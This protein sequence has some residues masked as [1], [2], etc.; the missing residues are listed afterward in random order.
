MDQ[1]RKACLF[2]QINIELTRNEHILVI[3]NTQVTVFMSLP[4]SVFCDI[5]STWLWRLTDKINK[6][7]GHLKRET[8]LSVD[9][10]TAFLTRLYIRA[11]FRKF[12]HKIM[13]NVL[14]YLFFPLKVVYLKKKEGRADLHSLP[15]SLLLGMLLIK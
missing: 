14:Y 6:E 3:M 4:E 9:Y 11:G 13:H 10:Q 15:L 8:T 5:A 1:S 2:A 7:C 12:K